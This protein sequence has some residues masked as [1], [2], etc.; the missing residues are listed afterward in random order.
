[1]RP[2]VRIGLIT[3]VMVL[4]LAATA[5]AQEQ[6]NQLVSMEYGT[7]FGYDIST[8]NVVTGQEFAFLLRLSGEVEAGA[9]FV[10]G[11][12]V[13]N[14]SFFRLDYAL[15]PAAIQL[16]TGMYNGTLGVSLG[17]EFVPLSRSFQGI[18]TELST[19]VEYLASN[20][21]GIDN[22]TVAVTIAASLGI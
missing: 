21:L 5:A 3:V 2:R 13:L 7:L 20:G 1:M 19:S 17:G 22:G 16:A 10:Q 4:V 11:T 12:G 6:D 15:G 9:S 8:N 14:G 18:T